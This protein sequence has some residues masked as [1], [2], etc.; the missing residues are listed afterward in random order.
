MFKKTLL[1]V[2]ASAIALPTSIA[3]SLDPAYAASYDPNDPAV[4]SLDQVSTKTPIAENPGTSSPS[5]DCN[6]PFPAKPVVEC[7]YVDFGTRM[8]L[9]T[10]AGPYSRPARSGSFPADTFE[11]FGLGNFY[12]QL[13]DAGQQYRMARDPAAPESLAITPRSLETNIR[14]VNTLGVQKR[15]ESSGAYWKDVRS[16]TEIR[17]SSGTWQSVSVG[18]QCEMRERL[19][20]KGTPAVKD[21]KGKILIPAVPDKIE[22]Y[23]VCWVVPETVVTETRNYGKEWGYKVETDTR[24]FRTLGSHAYYSRIVNITAN[25]WGRNVSVTSTTFYPTPTVKQVWCQTELGPGKLFGP[26]DHNGNSLKSKIGPSDSNLDPQTIER[27]WWTKPPTSLASRTKTIPG[28]GFAVLSDIGAAAESPSAANTFRPGSTT[29]EN[30]VV[31]CALEE[32]RPSYLA[33]AT[34]QSCKVLEPTHPLFGQELPATHELCN[35]FVPGNYLKDLSNSKEMLCTYVERR[36]VA[37][38]A[39]GS[40]LREWYV[41]RWANKAERVTFIHCGE[42]TEAKTN[43]DRPNSPNA[44]NYPIVK[45]YW[46][47]A[48]DSPEKG[49]NTWHPNTNYDFLT[50]GQ[51]FTCYANPIPTIVDVDSNTRVSSSSQLL[52]S[53]AEAQVIWQTPSR[54]IARNQSG[55]ITGWFRPDRANAW[56]TWTIL[57]GSAPWLPLLDPNDRRQPIFASNLR[58][59][60]P[61]TGQSVLDYGRFDDNGVQGWNNPTLYIRGY[62]GTTVADR[63]LS[64]GSLN[65]PAGR[66]VPFGV[67]TS[68]NTTIEKDTVVFGRPVTIDMPVTCQMNPAYLYY[69]SGRATG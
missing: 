11:G 2:L 63:A 17:N 29:A 51:T 59:I 23:E 61:D 40:N 27:Q 35:T 30:L 68:F 10:L 24:T 48:G 39:G 45:A 6:Q 13:K 62:K 65:V 43:P 18:E 60:S 15:Y 16:W 58:N 4:I 31:R 53:G 33:S 7:G 69:L 1:I 64:V 46:A 44:L 66:L 50:C 26:Y 37:E 12:Q 56:Q 21:S 28:G 52:A 5:S 9:D 36:W 20:K 38:A 34:N 67:Y 47:C 14:N 49:N 3:G 8:S 54:I 57:D 55:R 32:E 22:E 19:I 42:P 41:G 25:W